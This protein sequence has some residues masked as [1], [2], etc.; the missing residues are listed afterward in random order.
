MFCVHV[1]RFFFPSLPIFFLSYFAS[2]HLTT[3]YIPFTISCKLK[4]L[5]HSMYSVSS[6]HTLSS[7]LSSSEPRRGASTTND[8]LLAL[9]HRGE[10]RV[11]SDARQLAVDHLTP[12]SVSQLHCLTIR[13]QNMVDI[14]DEALEIMNTGSDLC[15]PQVFH[16]QTLPQ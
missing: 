6:C 9:M 5:K 4:F 13:R 16:Y 12:E 7:L 2:F 14:L 8:S 1:A 3:T 15:D 11:L 10:Q